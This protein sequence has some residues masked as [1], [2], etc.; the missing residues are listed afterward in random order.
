MTPPSAGIFSAS[1]EFAELCLPLCD[2]SRVFHE[3]TNVNHCQLKIPCSKKNSIKKKQSTVKMQRS[4]NE[5]S[6]L[7]H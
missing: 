2:L 3:K 5:T 7:I 4:L 6:N 1:P